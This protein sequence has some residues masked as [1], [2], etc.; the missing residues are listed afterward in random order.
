M[1]AIGLFIVLGGLL[2]AALGYA[3]KVFHVESNPLVDQIEDLMPGGQ[4]GQ[5][6]EAGCRQ[7]AEAMVKG[8]L[9][10]AAC[11]PGGAALSSAIAEMLGVSLEMSDDDIQWVAKIDESNCSGCTRCYKA[12]PFDAIVGAT[13]QMH[14]VIQDVCT[15]CQLCSQVCPQECLSIVSLSPSITTWCWPKPSTESPTELAS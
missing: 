15:G 12:C 2:G 13:K 7:A 9:N 6:G 11:P 5:C 14:T 8:D 10:P 4:C 3:S 1:I